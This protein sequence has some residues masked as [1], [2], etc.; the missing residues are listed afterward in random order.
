MVRT[1][2][3]LS[4]FAAII[5]GVMALG[6][7]ASLAGEPLCMDEK[8][9]GEAYNKCLGYFSM[10]GTPSQRKAAKEQKADDKA[11]RKQCETV[12]S[13]KHKNEVVV[14]GR[15]KAELYQGKKRA[16][17]AKDANRGVDGEKLDPISTD[18]SNPVGTPKPPARRC[19]PNHVSRNG[20]CV[21]TVKC[22]PGHAVSPSTGQC[23][24]GCRAGHVISPVTGQCVPGCRPG[25]VISKTGQCV[26]VVRR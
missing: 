11:A 16:Q 2:V 19:A 23:V 9:G 12:G 7:A 26:S 18:N 6:S 5:L 4:L 1:S 3:K 21:A 22:R 25:H 17:I 8:W 24:V 13:K 15:S 14:C 10:A 20:A